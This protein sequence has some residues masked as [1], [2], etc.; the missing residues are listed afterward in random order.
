M[1][2]ERLNSKIKTIV[3]ITNLP[4]GTREFSNRVQMIS[5]QLIIVGFPPSVQDFFCFITIT[6]NRRLGRLKVCTCYITKK[7]LY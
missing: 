3:N 2:P 5:D 1:I 6:N 4:F 7:V